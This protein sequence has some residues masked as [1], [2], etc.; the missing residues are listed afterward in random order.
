MTYV[1]HF[2]FLLDSVILELT[3]SLRKY[4]DVTLEKNYQIHPECEKAFKRS[5]WALEK[6]SWVQKGKEVQ[7]CV[8]RRVS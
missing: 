2:A 7:W 1:A 6:V 8:Y 3:S 4:G 5:G